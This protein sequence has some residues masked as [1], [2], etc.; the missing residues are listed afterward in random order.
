MGA[1][2]GEANSSATSVPMSKALTALNTLSQPAEV[3]SAP[4]WA[5]RLL[6]GQMPSGIESCHGVAASGGT[7]DVPSLPLDS[8]LLAR[9]LV[10]VVAIAKRVEEY[11]LQEQELSAPTM[12]RLVSAMKG[13]AGGGASKPPPAAGG[14]PPPAPPPKRP[15]APPPPPPGGARRSKKVEEWRPLLSSP[16]GLSTR[17][18]RAAKRS[19][20]GLYSN[21]RP[22]L[23]QP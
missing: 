6:Q 20:V 11:S 23:R 15:N 22:V 1:V 8:I 21:G 18:R 14:R 4:R 17:R 16:T 5:S 19:V 2:Y 12:R 9:Q 10:G 3:C 13:A 7:L